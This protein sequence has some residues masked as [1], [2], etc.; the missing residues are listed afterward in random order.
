MTALQQYQ[1][2]SCF[3]RS[4]RAYSLPCTVVQQFF[5]Q[6]EG[7]KGCDVMPGTLGLSQWI[8]LALQTL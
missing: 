6:V 2:P 4:T 1:R 7:H 5:P 8:P 3:S